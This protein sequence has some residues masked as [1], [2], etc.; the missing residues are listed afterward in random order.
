ML[1]RFLLLSFA[2]FT[3]LSL[4]AQITSERKAMSVGVYEGLQ[5]SVPDLGP[6]IVADI[7]SDF[8]K[9]FY[10]ARSRYDRRAKEYSAE[11]AKID[12]IGQGEE[13][14]LYL[15]AEEQGN[16]TLATMWVRFGDAFVSTDQFPNR[17]IEA[18]KI[19]MRFGLECAKAKVRMDIELMEDGLK[20]MRRDFDRLVSDKEG[21]ERDIEKAR[22]AIR[23]AEAAIQENMAAQGAKQEEIE[24]QLEAIETLKRELNDL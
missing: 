21:Y 1:R 20:D 16:G 4:T 14:T 3:T 9:D 6:D 5:L 15:V 19:L 22:E 10:D 24:R 8:T 13:V 2:L 12:A 17:Y 7:W 11:G 18:E 23:A